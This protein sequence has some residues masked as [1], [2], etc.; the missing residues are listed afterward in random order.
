MDKVNISFNEYKHGFYTNIPVHKYLIYELEHLFFEELRD[1]IFTGSRT[2]YNLFK[3]T[4]R[5]RVVF[6]HRDLERLRGQK[7]NIPFKGELIV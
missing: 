3:F 4:L 5:L 7:I 6:I 2:E 1:A